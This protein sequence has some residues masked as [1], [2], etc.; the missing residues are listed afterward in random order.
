MEVDEFVHAGLG[1][2]GERWVAVPGS[3]NILTASVLTRL[4][5]RQVATSIMGRNM[6]SMLQAR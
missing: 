5:P 1:Y 4:L 3:R 2:L 6:E